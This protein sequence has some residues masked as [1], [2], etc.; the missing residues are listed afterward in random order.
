MGESF[1]D[2]GA[3]NEE[4]LLHPH[5]NMRISHKAGDPVERVVASSPV[6]SAI[7]PS[8]S[9]F[10]LGLVDLPHLCLRHPAPVRPDEYPQLGS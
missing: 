10:C 3:A 8:L 2:L 9:S 5:P 4:I 7:L 6:K 1:G